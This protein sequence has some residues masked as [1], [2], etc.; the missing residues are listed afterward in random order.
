MAF[1]ELPHP[2]GAKLSRLSLS[3]I[4]CLV[5]PSRMG[6][7]RCGTGSHGPP[8]STCL[9]C[10]DRTASI[11]HTLLAGLLL[12]HI[13]GYVE[14]EPIHHS[15]SYKD[16]FGLEPPRRVFGVKTFEQG[17]VS[18][19]SQFS[20]LFWIQQNRKN[21]HKIIKRELTIAI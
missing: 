19:F 12:I 7:G 16:E 15:R 3:S 8:S 20:L 11:L 21:E 14:A 18:H 5:P 6:P 13:S 2:L 17:L 10:Q 4:A 1:K 9:G